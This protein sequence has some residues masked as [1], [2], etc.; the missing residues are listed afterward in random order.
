MTLKIVPEDGPEDPQLD[1][2]D[3][4]AANTPSTYP[5]LTC[6]D[7]GGL[8]LNIQEYG[9]AVGFEAP[10]N[11]ETKQLLVRCL[12]DLETLAAYVEQQLFMD[13]IT[14][15]K[16]E[17]LNGSKPYVV[18]P[19]IV[20]ARLMEGANATVEYIKHAHIVRQIDVDS[21]KD[22]MVHLYNTQFELENKMRL[23]HGLSALPRIVR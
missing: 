8:R 5:P 23:S 15:E 1:S 7:L 13:T 11:W 14:P 9:K 17:Q 2:D 3:G 18:V 4:Y 22:L 12:K 20:L 19:Q 10:V 21:S 16:M 6:P